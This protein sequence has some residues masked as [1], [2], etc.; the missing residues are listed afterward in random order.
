MNSVSLTGQLICRD[1]EQV[2]TVV[3]H[4]PLHVQ[5]TRAEEGCL[6]FEVQR[7]ENS[8]VWQVDEKFQDAEAFRAHQER[9]AKSTWGSA[10]AEIERKYTVKGL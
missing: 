8:L 10:T 9:V 1:D 5:L 4:L 7:L 6:A 3:Q 2:A